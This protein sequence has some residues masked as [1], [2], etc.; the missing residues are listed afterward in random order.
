M[1]VDPASVLTS[2]KNMAVVGERF[3]EAF[4]PQVEALTKAIQGGGGAT[5]LA[6]AY[7]DNMYRM[8]P[9]RLSKEEWK[10]F[11]RMVA[12]TLGMEEDD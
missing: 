6:E 10:A 5:L 8:I 3:Q 2:L 4:Q 11:Q 1:A 12:K 7:R 9:L